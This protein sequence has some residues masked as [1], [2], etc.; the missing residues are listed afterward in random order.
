MLI[1][2]DLHVLV[3]ISA[4]FLQYSDEMVAVCGIL[5]DAYKI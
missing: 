5:T 4:Q 1:L 3:E 2:S